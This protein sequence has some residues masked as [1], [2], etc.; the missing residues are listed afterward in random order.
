MSERAWRRVFWGSAVLA[1]LLVASLAP[2]L[3]S[4]TELVRLRNALV[5]ESVPLDA[6]WIPD[7]PPPG[8]RVESA[9]PYP[10]FSAAVSS[11][12][13]TVPGDD[14]QTALRIGRY[15]L[16][17]VDETSDS[18]PIKKGLEETHRLIVERGAG[19]CG[20]FVDT[21]TG[22]ATAAGL[23]TRSWAFSFD[24]FGGHGHIFNEVWDRAAGRWLMIDVF[25][26]Y[27]VVDEQERPLSALEFRDRLLGGGEIDWRPV[28]GDARPGFK[29]REKALDYYRRGAPEWYMWW[30]DNVFEYDSHPLVSRA[31]VLSRALE[32]GAAIAVGVHP[33][34]RVL[35]SPDNVQARSALAGVRIHLLVVGVLLGVLCVVLLTSWFGVR[36]ARAARRQERAQA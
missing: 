3:T 7:Q 35:Q 34:I 27:Y 9:K 10:S 28:S 5:Y 30:G 14:W 11:K 25:N 18:G 31:G 33:G 23:H 29:Y 2:Y 17:R 19:Y 13:L 1:L 22:L 20:D 4:S 8:Y 36:A 12:A 16:Q 6:D 26:N 21:F 15:L 32:Q 24:G